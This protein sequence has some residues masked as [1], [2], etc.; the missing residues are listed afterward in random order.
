MIKMIASDMDGT[1][2]RNGAQAL[3]GRMPRILEGLYERGIL[4]TAASG[5]QYANLRNL[6]GSFADKAAYICENGA[7]AVYR[8]QIIYKAVMDRAL[9]QSLM[10]DIQAAKDCEIQ[11]SGVET[12]YIQPKSPAYTDYLVHELKNRV[13]VVEDIFSTR[14]DYIKISAYVHGSRTEEWLARF[15]EKWGGVFTL[16]STCDHWIDFIPPDIHKGKAMRALM[17]AVQIKK[18]EVMAFGDNYNDLELLSCAAES[19]AVDTAKPEVIAACRHVCSLV[20]DVLEG[21]LEA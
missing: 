18:E 11:L 2:L 14:E 9:G 6:L 15:R 20:E 7:F 1:L 4:F 5:R 13:T 19:Y 8:G 16:A 3:S 17:E 12:A 10:R 21:L